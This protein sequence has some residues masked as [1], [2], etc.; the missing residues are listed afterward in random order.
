M[1][2]VLHRTP[3]CWIIK[4]IIPGHD[5]QPRGP[6]SSPVLP[7]PTGN[8][9][10][11]I[12]TG[13]ITG[14]AARRPECTATVKRQRQRGRP[15]PELTR[16]GAGLACSCPCRAN[17]WRLRPPLGRPEARRATTH[18][19]TAAAFFRQRR[20]AATRCGAR[21]RANARMIE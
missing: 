16:G 9:S 17:E 6:L 19:A 21:S 4:C 5:R 7:A 13:F 3:P 15:A 12:S 10:N 2:M 11:Q 14:T 1:K 18:G 20:R 8:P